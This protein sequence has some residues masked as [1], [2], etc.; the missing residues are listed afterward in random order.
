MNIKVIIC[1]IVILAFCNAVSAQKTGEVVYER[2]T[3]YSKIIDGLPYLSDEEKARQKLSWGK[4]E[5]SSYP[6][7]LQFDDSQSLYTYGEKEKS[8]AYSWKK[9]EFVLIHDRSADQIKHQIVLGGQL[10]LV[11]DSAPTYKWKILN[12]IREV[13]GFLCMKAETQDTIK[14]QTIHA[15]FTTEIPVSAGPE[16]Y[17]GLPGLILMLEINNG[18]AIIEASEITLDEP[19]AFKMPKKIKGKE[20]SYSAYRSMLH[21]FYEQCI[22]GKRNPF[23][24][25]RY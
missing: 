6:Y 16:G 15:W 7:V 4:D 12:E 24:Q 19:I 9:D 11:E 13:E 10:Y 17:S 21:K 1:G 20:V 23:W 5:G 25:S 14:N 8:Y 18:T 2:T 3:Y 22:D